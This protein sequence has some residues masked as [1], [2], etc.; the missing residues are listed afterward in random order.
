MMRL[1]ST[2]NKHLKGLAELLCG[3]GSNDAQ[4]S[5]SNVIYICRC[6]D[7]RRC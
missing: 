3:N 4:G 7:V 1:R 2:L 6:C 5:G